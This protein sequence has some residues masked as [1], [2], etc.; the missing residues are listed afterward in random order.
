MI[1]ISAFKKYFALDP[2]QKEF[3]KTGQRIFLNKPQELLTFLKPLA[4]FDKD[5]DGARRQCGIIL[6]V[7]FVCGFF[8]IILNANDILSGSFFSVLS[9]LGSITFFAALI[10]YFILNKI[11]IDNNLR[12][13][14]VPVIN[15]VSQDMAAADKIRV[16]LDLRGKCIVAKKL[17]EHKDDPGWFSYPKVTTT[18]YKDNWLDGSAMLY[19]GSKLFFSVT[20]VVTKVQR[21][22]KN[23]RGKVKSKTKMKIKHQIKVGMGLKQK[24]YQFV[25][26]AQLQ[27]A[28]D[29]LKQKAGRNRSIVSLTRV[30]K[31]NKIDETLDPVS[32]LSLLG[33]IL[34]S[35]RPAA[36]EGKKV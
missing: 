11:N 20:D 4:S 33:K 22:K 23:F 7:V 3:I 14:V 35:A 6:V 36:E 34:M 25:P 5:C 28:G 24:N 16:K 29:R 9:T 18:T 1:L 15:A 8:G 2:K 27:E 26:N 10:S 17:K 13:F 19:D 12:E 21:T 30:E 31:S 32:M